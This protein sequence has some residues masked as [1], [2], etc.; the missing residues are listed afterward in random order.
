[1]TQE[2][3]YYLLTIA[4]KNNIVRLLFLYMVFYFTK[5]VKRPDIFYNHKK[6]A[7]VNKMFSLHRSYYPLFFAPFGTIQTVLQLFRKPLLFDRTEILIETAHNGS[8]VLDLAE[9]DSRTRKNALLVHGF[10]GSGNSSYMRGLTAHLSTEGYRVFCFNARG[11]KSKLNNPIFFHIGWTVDLKAAVGFILSNYPGT[12][13]IFGFSMG[14]NWV[15]K[16]FGEEK[17]NPRIIKGGAVCLPF[18]F[19]KIGIH[20]LKNPYTRFC[21][22]LLAMNFVRYMNRNREIFRVAGYDV[23]VVRKC[24]SVQQID[25]MVTTKVF[26][27]KEDIN[28]YYK[29]QSCV[30]YIGKIRVPFIIL[31]AYDDPLI[32]AFSIDK[33]ACLKN[34]NI[35]LVIAHKGGHLGFLSNKLDRTWSE[36]VLLDFIKYF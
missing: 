20:F 23:D 28:E 30:N 34:E 35:L 3:I 16:F 13:E 10:N 24:E 8:I 5:C 6:R 7:S 31:N 1:M 18:D 22:K 17:L 36:D 26:G 29:K 4:A 9:A 25:M 15:T 21:N 12:L 27:I 32:P 33:A 14:A 11:I 2:I 19:S